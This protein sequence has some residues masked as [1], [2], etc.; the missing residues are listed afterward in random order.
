MRNEKEIKKEILNYREENKNISCSEHE[1]TTDE[2]LE[3]SKWLFK[4]FK[5]FQVNHS[6]DY[7]KNIM[8]RIGV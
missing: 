7:E 4:K 3:I 6:T 1:M 2:Y 5:N 8:L